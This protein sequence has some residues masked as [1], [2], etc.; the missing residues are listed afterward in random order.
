VWVQWFPVLWWDQCAGCLWE[1]L[2]GLTLVGKGRPGW[3]EGDTGSSAVSTEAFLLAT[4]GTRQ[5]RQPSKSSRLGWGRKLDLHTFYNRT[6]HGLG[7]GLDS[8]L[9]LRSVAGEGRQQGEFWATG[10]SKS[11]SPAREPGPHS[12]VSAVVVSPSIGSINVTSHCHHSVNLLVRWE[13]EVQ[14]KNAVCPRPHSKQVGG[15][16]SHS[17]QSLKL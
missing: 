9:Q 17:F 4:R 6:E 15:G 5:W 14:R 3:A 2:S 10:R 8:S 1:A 16:F 13:N 12:I 7:L 11:F